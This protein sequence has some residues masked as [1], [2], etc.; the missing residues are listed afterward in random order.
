MLSPLPPLSPP[1]FWSKFDQNVP[2]RKSFIAAWLRRMRRRIE[3]E[4]EE[5]EVEKKEEKEWGCC[6]FQPECSQYSNPF[7]GSHPED[8]LREGDWR[9][10]SE[11]RMS[12]NRGKSALWMS[13]IL[14]LMILL[15]T[16]S[17]HH[18]HFP[19]WSYWLTGL[20]LICGQQAIDKMFI[21]DNHMVWPARSKVS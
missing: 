11:G 20:Q 8:G 14:I 12:N 16:G 13:N 7:L 10:F 19:R 1:I 15:I 3:K 17:N 5:E 21:R 9:S 6:S 18:M 2:G 4:E